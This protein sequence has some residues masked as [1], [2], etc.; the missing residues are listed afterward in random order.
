M[1]NW[2]STM[3]YRSND[4]QSLES[5]KERKK[6]EQN[7]VFYALQCVSGCLF[8]IGGFMIKSVFSEMKC[9]SKRINQLEV[10]MARNTSENETLFKRLDGIE[11][12]L[13]KILEN[14]RQK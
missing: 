4:L 1:R 11:I 13:D 3:V 7:L 6:M 10:D 12:K 2:L 14:W 5:K 8:A 9:Q